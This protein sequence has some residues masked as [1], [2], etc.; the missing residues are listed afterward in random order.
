M[1]TNSK[2]AWRVKDWAA[3]VGIGLTSTN[4][5]I[6]DKKIPTTTIGRRRLILIS[7]GEFIATARIDRLQGGAS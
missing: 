5:L 3:A 4:A 6:R 7:P 2:V 1:D